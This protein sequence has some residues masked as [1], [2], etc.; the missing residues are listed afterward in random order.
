ML[1]YY[2]MCSLTVINLKDV[3]LVDKECRAE[4][5]FVRECVLLL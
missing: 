3:E 4:Q 1:S 5:V 2:R